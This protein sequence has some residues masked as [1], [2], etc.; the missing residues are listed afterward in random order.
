[1]ITSEMIPGRSQGQKVRSGPWRAAALLLRQ[2][3]EPSNPLDRVTPVPAL[4]CLCSADDRQDQPAETH[5]WHQPPKEIQ[6]CDATQHRDN[7]ERHCRDHLEVE[8]LRRFASGVGARCGQGVDKTWS[9]KPQE[10]NRKVGKSGNTSAGAFFRLRLNEGP[11][12]RMETERPG[13]CWHLN[14]AIEGLV[15][16]LAGR[17]RQDLPDSLV[18]LDLADP[19]VGICVLQPGF[20]SIALLW[21]DTHAQTRVLISGAHAIKD[22]RSCTATPSGTPPDRPR[23]C[24]QLARHQLPPP[25]P[26]PPPPEKPPPPNELP[27]P[28]PVPLLPAEGAGLAALVRLLVMK[29]VLKAARW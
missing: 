25:P 4:H 10:E 27:P 12:S 3:L 19:A 16:L 7:D 23:E 17:C 1:M 8:G 13:W 11:V 2:H 26:P 24:A 6:S 15:H 28:K 20:C 14:Q 21:G 9:E 22:R 18:E 5:E 29:A